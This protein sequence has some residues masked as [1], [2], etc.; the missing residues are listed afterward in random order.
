[1]LDL[2]AQQRLKMIAAQL[3]LDPILAGLILRAGDWIETACWVYND[4]RQAAEIHVNRELCQTLPVDE[5]KAL[6]LHELY[7]HLGYS[8]RRHTFPPGARANPAAVNLALDISLERVLSRGPYGPALARLNDRLLLKNLPEHGPIPAD[9][10]RWLLVHA[11]PPLD[12]MPKAHRQIHQHLWR[13][14]LLPSPEEVYQ[15]IQPLFSEDESVGDSMGLG[16]QIELALPGGRRER[17]MPRQMPAGR[18][19]QASMGRFLPR[20]T[21]RRLQRSAS[22]ES[23][24]WGLESGF[25]EAQITPHSIHPAD[26]SLLR[27]WLLQQQSRDDVSS[28]LENVL[29]D[30]LEDVARLPYL[31]RPTRAELVRQ[32]I[33]WPSVHYANRVEAGWRTLHVY[34]DVSGSMCEWLGEVVAVLQGIRE[35]LPAELFLFDVEVRPHPMERTVSGDLFVG[36]GTCFDAVMRHAL[37]HQ[38]TDCLVLTD[39][40]SEVSD[41]VQEKMREADLKARAIL[42]TYPD[43]GDYAEWQTWWSDVYQWDAH[44]QGDPYSF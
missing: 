3:G 39:G 12:R 17:L 40:D 38:V 13:P 18:E 36:D 23:G 28:C 31:M 14:G 15:Q 9:R 37:E 19:R 22:H 2:L 21:R 7:H 4:S 11:R 8:Q 27:N 35:M 32:A 16:E 34:V 20:P 41:E 26:A 43:Y 24:G 1:M 6:V 33:G 29:G 25:E 42:F 30:A 5:L 10:S 44:P